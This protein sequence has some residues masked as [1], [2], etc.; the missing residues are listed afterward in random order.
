LE[1]MTEAEM[2]A[3][4]KDVEEEK[5]RKAARKKRAAQ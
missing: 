2:E 3:L 1:E 4:M 5:E